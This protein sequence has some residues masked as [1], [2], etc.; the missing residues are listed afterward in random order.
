[1]VHMPE[2]EVNF[3]PTIIGTGPVQF[4]GGFLAACAYVWEQGPIDRAQLAIY[5]KSRCFRPAMIECLREDD[6]AP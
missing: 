5:T 4:R 1:M 2:A 3:L 6:S